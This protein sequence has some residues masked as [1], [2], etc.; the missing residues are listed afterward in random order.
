MYDEYL[1][2][3]KETL[4]DISKRFG[5]DKSIVIEINQLKDE[6]ILPGMMLL[7]PKD[8]FDLKEYVTVRGDT[9]DKIER[10]KHISFETLL[11]FNNLEELSL[12]P[13]QKIFYPVSEMTYEVKPTDVLSDLLR[14]LQIDPLDLL[15]K[16]QDEWLKPGQVLKI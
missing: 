14:N 7:L 2:K 16:N 13:G 3:T 12:E 6:T 4:D 15:R 5:K 10:S 1:V 11:S 9:L 8:H